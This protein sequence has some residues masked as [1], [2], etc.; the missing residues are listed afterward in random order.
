ME[1]VLCSPLEFSAEFSEPIERRHNFN[2]RQLFL[3]LLSYNSWL[4]VF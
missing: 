2:G 1:L 3:E 4:Q